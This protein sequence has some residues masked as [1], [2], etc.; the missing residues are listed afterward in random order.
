MVLFGVDGRC[1]D[2][3]RRPGTAQGRLSTLV[4]S[5]WRQ[6]LLDF[7]AVVRKEEQRAQAGSDNRLHHEFVSPSEGKE[8]DHDRKPARNSIRDGRSAFKCREV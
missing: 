5:S 6:L 8:R 3:L 1:D 7:A 2:V 4:A